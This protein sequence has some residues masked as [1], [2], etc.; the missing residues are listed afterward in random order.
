M[1]RQFQRSL[2][3]NIIFRYSS[4]LILSTGFIV[5]SAQKG[6]VSWVFYLHERLDPLHLEALIN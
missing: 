4:K 1:M 3:T 6:E 2:S 5:Y